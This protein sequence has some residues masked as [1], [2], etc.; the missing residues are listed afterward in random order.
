MSEENKQ[1][2][3]PETKKPRSVTAV[4]E[5]DKSAIIDGE[6]LF[7]PKLYK[8]LVYLFSFFHAELYHKVLKSQLL[9][10]LLLPQV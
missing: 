2:S 10:L 8:F 9:L 4:T 6:S 3:S 1:A 7:A 5:T